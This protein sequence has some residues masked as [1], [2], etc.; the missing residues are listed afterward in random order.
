M[1]I[2]NFSKNYK[3]RKLDLNDRQIYYDLCIENPNYYK[4]CPPMVTLDTLKEDL[5]ALPPKKTYEDKYYI[6]YFKDDELIAI[7]DFIDKYPHDKCGFIGF[8]MMN[9]KYQG[10]GIGK[11]IISELSEH[12]KSLDYS[13]IRLGYVE[14]NNE[15]KSFWLANGFKPTPYQNITPEYTVNVLIK[16]LN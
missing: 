2:I 9:K 3:I 12:L 15:A 1:D 16:Y 13:E 10:K 6:G 7:M 5:E 11:T 8:F 4:H 14:T